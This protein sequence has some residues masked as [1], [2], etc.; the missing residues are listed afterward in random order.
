MDDY[1]PAAFLFSDNEQFRREGMLNN[2]F[3][4]GNRIKIG[5]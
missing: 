2:S 5:S 3:E 1:A 4:R